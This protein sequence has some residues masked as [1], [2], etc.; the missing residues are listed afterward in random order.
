[1]A[2]TVKFNLKFGEVHIRTV[3]DLQK[4]FAMEDVLAHF[5]NGLLLKFLERRGYK[6]YA[7]K[8]AE[9]AEKKSGMDDV[10]RSLISIFD[11]D[12]DKEAVDE[13]FEALRLRRDRQSAYEAYA[14]GAANEREVVERYFSEYEKIV[15]ELIADKDDLGKIKAL[16]RELLDTYMPILKKDWRR[17]FF[18]L[19]DAKVAYPVLHMLTQNFFRQNWLENWSTETEKKTFVAIFWDMYMK[20]AKDEPW[21][22]KSNKADASYWEDIEASGKTYMILT[23]PSGAKVRAPGD[24]KN[25]LSS[26]ELN[27]KFEIFDGIQYRHNST[28]DHLVYVE[29]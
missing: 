7:A 17:L 3:T 23:A 26:N 13:Y 16:T 15:N 14:K 8:V 6:E 2:K 10:T 1:M 21:V 25:E 29:V 12:E 24:I 19:N 18:T 5:E 22:R 9:L 27:Q 11:I 4:N 20:S 28:S